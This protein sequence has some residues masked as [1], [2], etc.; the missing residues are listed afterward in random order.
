M[1]PR[2]LLSEIQTVNHEYHLSAP[3]SSYSEITIYIMEYYTGGWEMMPLLVSFDST[4][5]KLLKTIPAFSRLRRPPYS[6]SRRYWFQ[7]DHSILTNVFCVLQVLQDELEK[8]R[9]SR[10]FHN[11][12]NIMID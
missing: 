1:R 10:P 6:C 11:M 2:L 3:D 8:H 5:R 7:K 12:I 9:V 4:Y